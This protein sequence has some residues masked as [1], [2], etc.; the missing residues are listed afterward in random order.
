MAEHTEAEHGAAAGQPGAEGALDHT[1]TEVAGGHGADAAA[2]GAE[3]VGMPQL[4]FGTFPNQIFW[5]I[6]ALV[7]IYFILTKLALPRIAGILADRQGTITNDI[8]KAEELKLKAQAAE[9]SHQK[10]LADARAEST[11]IANDAKAEVQRDLDVAIAKADEEISAKTA[12]SETRIA[13][14]RDSA[15]DNVETVARDTAAAIVAAL[16]AQADD[17][18][19]AE[20]VSQQMKR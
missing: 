4:D 2:H 12:E 13:E 15:K 8:A 5:L 19:L 6:V 18:R 20:A 11:R 3:A 16:G 1:A 17:A 10:A 7:A 9:E 14:I